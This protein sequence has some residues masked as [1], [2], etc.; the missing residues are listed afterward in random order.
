M[1]EGLGYEYATNVQGQARAFDAQHRQAAVGVPRHPAPRRVRLRHVEERVGRLHR[2]QRRVD[3]DHGG[4][5][6]GHRLPAGRNADHRRIRRQPPRRQPVRRIARRGRPEDRRAQVALP[7]R[8]SPA[9]GP[10]HVVGAAADR[11]DDRRQAAQDRRRALEAGLALLLRPH[12][13]RADLADRRAAGSAD[14]DEARAD[15]ADAAV[16]DQAGAVRA[17]L[18]RRERPDRLHAGAARAGA[19]E[20]EVLPLGADAVRSADGSGVEAA[21]RRSTSAT[22]PAAPTGRAPASTS[23]PASSIR[24]PA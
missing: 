20:P 9:V 12:H 24:R 10:R 15:V 11:H 1:F 13:R 21:R 18:H 14:D 2:Q 17:H 8:A 4:P 7:V 19:G 22:P 16:P 3:A 6:S 23:R 5:G